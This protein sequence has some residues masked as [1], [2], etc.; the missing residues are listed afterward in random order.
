MSLNYPYVYRRGVSG[1][2]SP[3]QKINYALKLLE[4]RRAAKEKLGL[5]PSNLT[6][7]AIANLVGVYSANTIARWDHS[8]MSPHAV[9]YRLSNK[10]AKSLFSVLEERIFAGWVI[11]QDLT[12]QGS[13]TFN[14]KE[15][16]FAYFGRRTSS[17]YIS[18]FMKRNR[19]SLKQVGRANRNEIFETTIDTAVTFLETLERVLSDYNFRPDQ[20]K[21]FDKTYLI[22]APYHGY[23]K[24]MSPTGSNKPRKQTCDRGDGMFTNILLIFYLYFTYILLIFYLYFTYILLIFYLYFTNILLIFY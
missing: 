4:R 17:S 13:T 7:K 6:Y 11:Y 3:R 8:D 22:T 15:F 18:K 5:V 10:A 23:V 19:L 16:V 20:I 1:K 9:N 24:H 14:F 12:L 2:L 21:V